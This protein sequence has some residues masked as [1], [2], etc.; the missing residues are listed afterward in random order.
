MTTSEQS[1][2]I[3]TQNHLRVLHVFGE[4][5][6]LHLDGER[7]AGK[8]TVWT[9]VTS[10]GGGPPPHYH[11]NEDEAFY[12]LEGRVAFLLNGEWHEVGPGSTAFMPRS[13][14]HTFKT[15]AINRVACCS[16]RRPQE[17]TNFLRAALRNL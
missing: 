13:I 3:V 1:A 11:L 5:V 8:L 4:E 16:R 10:P 17:S 2:I 14:V 9:G 6:T 15:S 7:T 12:V